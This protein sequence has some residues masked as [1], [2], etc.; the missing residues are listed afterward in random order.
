[1]YYKGKSNDIFSLKPSGINL[2]KK[3]KNPL[4]GHLGGHL[5]GHFYVIPT[6]LTKL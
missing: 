1:M 2:T 6:R 5:H 4:H 3:Y